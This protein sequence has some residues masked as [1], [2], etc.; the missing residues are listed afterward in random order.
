MLK[1][2]SQ[3]EWEINLGL[4]FNVD[5]IVNFY[6]TKFHRIEERGGARVDG[7]SG[8]CWRAEARR[9]LGSGAKERGVRAFDSPPH[10]RRRRHVEAR[11]RRRVD[12]DGV[13]VVVVGEA[14]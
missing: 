9:R 14:E 7:G 3:L 2:K 8:C 6:T 5:P 4:Y 11:P 10:L 12:R 13:G 1:I